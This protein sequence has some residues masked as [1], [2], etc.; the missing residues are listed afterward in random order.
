MHNSLIKVVDHDNLRRDPQT[1]AIVD[2]NSTGFEN[3]LKIKNSRQQHQ[4]RLDHLET[5]INNFESNLTDIK[6][7]LQ[8]LLETKH[9]HNN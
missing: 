1:N 9:G 2:I 6:S 4:D 5:K 3:Y 8:Q 7:L